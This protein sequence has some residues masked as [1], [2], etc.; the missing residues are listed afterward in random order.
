[1]IYWDVTEYTITWL[2]FEFIAKTNEQT[3]N[4]LLNKKTVQQ[5]YPP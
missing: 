3:N 1:M 4:R 2:N 5:P